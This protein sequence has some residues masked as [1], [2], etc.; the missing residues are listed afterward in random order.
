MLTMEVYVCVCIT[1]G[2]YYFCDN[3]IEY[4]A[5]YNFPVVLWFTTNATS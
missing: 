3:F 5:C 2:V 4:R 1:V